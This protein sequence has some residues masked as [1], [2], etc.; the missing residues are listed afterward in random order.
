MSL[1][2]LRFPVCTIFHSAEAEP[3]LAIQTGWLTPLSAAS[4]CPPTMYT[5]EACR[6]YQAITSSWPI[7]CTS[8]S[9]IYQSIR[10]TS[11]SVYKEPVP[12]WVTRTQTPRDSSTRGLPT[13]QV[14]APATLSFDRKPPEY[15]LRV[16]LLRT[17]ERRV[18]RRAL[19]GAASVRRQLVEE[20]RLQ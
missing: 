19:A 20:V 7:R 3:S 1:R 13:R 8:S 15:Q 9:M 6:G 11:T 10:P 17:S 5:Q 18:L 2:R 4:S 14:A 16:K 12:A